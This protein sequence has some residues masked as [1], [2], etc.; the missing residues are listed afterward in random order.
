[1]PRGILAKFAFYFPLVAPHIICYL[2]SKKKGKVDEDISNQWNN[3]DIVD[4]KYPV[5]SLGIVLVMYPP[6]RN[7]FYMRMG[8]VSWLLSL[9]LNPVR[10]VTMGNDGNIQGGFNLVHGYG[11]T[12]NGSSVIGRNCTVLHNV[13]IGVGRGGCP[14]IGDNCFI[15]TGA[16]IIGKVKIGDNV[17]I[18][19]GTVVT[20]NVPSNATVVGSASRVILGK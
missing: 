10:N 13:T 16:I 15:G 8:R 9:F 19:A 4:E 17:K 7:V 5:I 6:Y 3:K 14:V 18:G 20:K 1:M 12:I 11:T 2:F